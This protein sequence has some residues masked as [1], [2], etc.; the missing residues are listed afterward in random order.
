MALVRYEHAELGEMIKATLEKGHEFFQQNF[1]FFLRADSSAA[2]SFH[3]HNFST[4]PPSSLLSI[5]QTG[6]SIRACTNQSVPEEHRPLAQ[7]RQQETPGLTAS[8][9]GKLISHRIQAV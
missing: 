6:Q 7:P 2:V 8:A 5:S 3:H 9:P 1:F 4:L